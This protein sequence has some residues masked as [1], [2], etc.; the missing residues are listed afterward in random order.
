MTVAPDATGT[1][2]FDVTPT[3]TTRY[4]LEAEGGASPALLVQ[5]APRLTLSKPTALEPGVLTGT[6]KPKLQGAQIAIERRKGSAWV[7]VGE[8]TADATGAFELEVDAAVPA[9]S[10]RARSA[11]MS[12]FVAGTSPTVQ[13]LG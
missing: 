9:G 11:P 1:L 8:V 5:V 13:V 12:G 7:L 2:S 3:R 4:R 6:I 10:Y